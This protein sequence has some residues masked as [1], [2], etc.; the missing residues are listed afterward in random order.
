[1][2]ILFQRV[3]QDGLECA[4]FLQSATS[5]ADPREQIHGWTS[6]PPVEGGITINIGDMLSK[7][8]LDPL[9]GRPRLCSNM[10]RVRMPVGEAA[11]RARYSIAF[12]AQADATALITPQVTSLR[13]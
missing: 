1:M 12:F 8:S 3:G 5:S 2:T 4:P 11:G 9:T 6:A 10:H 7:W 13:L